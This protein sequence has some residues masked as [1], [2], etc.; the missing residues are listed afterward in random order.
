MLRKILKLPQVE[1]AT[2]KAAQQS[3]NEYRVSQAVKAGS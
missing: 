1:E 3:T 2:G